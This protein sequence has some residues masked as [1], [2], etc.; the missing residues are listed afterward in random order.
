MYYIKCLATYFLSFSNINDTYVLYPG[1][2]GEARERARCR[3]SVMVHC[4]YSTDL[5]R[6]APEYDCIGVVVLNLHKRYCINHINAHHVYLLKLCQQITK[7]DI[8]CACFRFHH[9]RANYK[10]PM[11]KR[12]LLTIKIVCKRVGWEF[13][14]A[15]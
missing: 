11:Y 3:H 1:E 14:R 9:Q 7:P 10:V 15:I 12:S 13:I 8:F 6:T 5:K 4:L 2:D